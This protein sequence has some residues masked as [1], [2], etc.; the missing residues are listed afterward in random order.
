MMMIRRTRMRMI[1]KWL[2][3]T[4][5][6][7][8]REMPPYAAYC[9][10]PRIPVIRQAHTQSNNYPSCSE[11]PSKSPALQYHPVPVPTHVI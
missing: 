6:H 1:M 4:W 7:P 5:A 10:P 8:S 2:V 11:N 3:W 9:T